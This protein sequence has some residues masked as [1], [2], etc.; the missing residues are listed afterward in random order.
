MPMFAATSLAACAAAALCTGPAVTP[1]SSILLS[2]TD[3]R[4]ETR[5]VQLMC[6]PTLGNHPQADSACAAL[7]QVD[8][9]FTRLP[10]KDQTCTMIHS[11]VRASAQ[12]HWR[13]SP[14]EFTTEYPNR[15]LADAHSNS[16]FAF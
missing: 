4:G 8:G 10:V 11:P 7:E 9:D 16:V 14:V 5:S 15:C 3:S 6:D 13:G 12:G 2:L 1:E